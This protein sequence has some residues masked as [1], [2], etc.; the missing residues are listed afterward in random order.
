MTRNEYHPLR[1]VKP[2]HSQLVS[3]SMIHL[4]QPSHIERL[5]F[6]FN[7]SSSKDTCEHLLIRRSDS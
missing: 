5:N 7:G 1:L 3:I 6:N 4:N 2:I